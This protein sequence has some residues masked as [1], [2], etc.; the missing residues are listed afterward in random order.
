MK[1]LRGGQATTV[2]YAK[3]TPYLVEAIKAQQKEIERLSKEVEN[4]KANQIKK[5]ETF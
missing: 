3:M 1:V 2:D 5:N 4:L